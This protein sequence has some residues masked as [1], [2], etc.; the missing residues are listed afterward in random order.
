MC[1]YTIYYMY[2]LRHLLIVHKYKFL[3]MILRLPYIA[4]RN[5]TETLHMAAA[6]K[7]RD[8]IYYGRVRTWHLKLRY[9]RLS[10]T[11]NQRISLCDFPVD[12]KRGIWT[13]VIKGGRR[14]DV[15][16]YRPVTVLSHIAKVVETLMTKLFSR[17]V[18]PLYHAA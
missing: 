18:L 3:R 8:A 7:M 2:I 16:R 5:Q 6:T 15:S 1:L 12:L 11:S 10:C 14:I 4:Y 17:H 13:P 9:W